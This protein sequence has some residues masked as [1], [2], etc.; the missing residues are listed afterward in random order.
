MVTLLLI[1]AIL[2][3]GIGVDLSAVYAARSA[4]RN[5][6]QMGANSVLTYYD[7]YLQE[8]YGLYGAVSSDDNLTSMVDAY[9]RATLLGEDVTDENIR[10]FQ[11]LLDEDSLCVS[12]TDLDG[13]SN[14][15]ILRRQ[16]E[17][18]AKWRVPVTLIQELETLSLLSGDVGEQIAADNTAVQEKIAL[19]Q[20]IFNVTTAYVAV[21]EAALEVEETYNQ[22]EEEIRSTLNER[23]GN[24]WTNLN[25]QTGTKVSYEL[26]LEKISTAAIN[27]VTARMENNSGNIDDDEFLAVENELLEAIEKAY[28][29]V[30]CYN[31]TLYNI[32]AAAAGG[33]YGSN[34][35]FDSHSYYKNV[36]IDGVLDVLDDAADEIL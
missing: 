24:L 28:S 14:V 7:T 27:Y 31:G 17:E 2:I 29:L 12:V 9:V 22:L 30:E 15:E 1:P 5:A 25:A 8:L 18:Y 6:N 35:L 16:I 36:E 23:L 32:S 21:Y 13:L 34:W 10:T 4:I 33:V 20:Q 19:D 3:T 26:Q 11:L